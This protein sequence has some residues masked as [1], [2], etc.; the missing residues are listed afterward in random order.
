[1]GTVPEGDH[2]QEDDRCRRRGADVLPA[3]QASWLIPRPLKL[4]VS[5]LN[6]HALASA[7]RV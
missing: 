1:M 7:S 5:H 3:I 6:Q 4:F 2:M